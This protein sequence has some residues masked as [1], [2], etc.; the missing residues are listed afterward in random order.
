[1]SDGNQGTRF[2]AFAFGIPYLDVVEVSHLTKKLKEIVILFVLK[3]KVESGSM[4]VLLNEVD[5]T[6]DLNSAPVLRQN[7]AVAFIDDN[8]F[9]AVVSNNQVVHSISIALVPGVEYLT[10]ALNLDNF[11]QLT[12]SG[13]LGVIN[14]DPSD[15]F[16]YPDGTTI[17]SDASEQSLHQWGQSCMFFTIYV[18]LHSVCVLL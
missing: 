1:M 13:L 8:T 6:S 5:I 7:L 3:V 16:M 10:Y 4:I 14:G 12:T 15:D 11:M 17:P 9:R 2:T 18:A